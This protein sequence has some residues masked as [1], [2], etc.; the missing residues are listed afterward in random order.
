M[1]KIKLFSPYIR[2]TERLL[3]TTLR[4]NNVCHLALATNCTFGDVRLVGGS[5]SMQGRVEICGNEE[6]GTVCDDLWTVTDGTVV[7][8]QLG[9]G[10][11]ML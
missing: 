4:L 10:P 6:W 11:G 7:C 8:R 9:F 3:Y 1:H 5:T 2:S